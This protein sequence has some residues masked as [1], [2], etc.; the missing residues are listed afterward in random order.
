MI[1]TKLIC[2]NSNEIQ[3]IRIRILF[4]IG[5][6]I[7]FKANVNNEQ[8]CVSTNNPSLS[9]TLFRRVRL[10]TTHF[11]V[12]YFSSLLSF[13]ST[14]HSQ[15]KQSTQNIFYLY[16]F[17]FNGYNNLLLLFINYKQILSLKTG[18]LLL[19]SIRRNHYHQTIKHD[20]T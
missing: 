1:I 19:S 7:N 13:F 16:F 9:Q 18:V 11:I 12:H 15:N 17:S 4:F 10:S 14:P 20:M 5:G 2:Q 8:S 3:I 6:K